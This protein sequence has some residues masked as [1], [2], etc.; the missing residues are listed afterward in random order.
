M[1]ST[2]VIIAV[3]MASVII[4]IIALPFF[5]ATRKRNEQ[6]LLR[7]R[8]RERLQVYYERAL[9]NIRDLD[10]DHAIQKIGEQEYAVERE[11]WV[12][13]GIHALKALDT[14][15]TNSL[16]ATTAVTDTAIDD[17]IDTA[18]EAAVAQARSQ[19]SVSTP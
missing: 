18:I 1:S 12:Q 10:D 7:E 2:G 15:N 14:L 17:A 6:D 4:I 16:F 9:K 19:K 13:R 5:T 11:I 8:Q 3:L